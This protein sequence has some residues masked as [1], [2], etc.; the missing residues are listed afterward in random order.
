MRNYVKIVRNMKLAKTPIPEDATVEELTEGFQKGLR[1]LGIA[2]ESDLSITPI[3]DSTVNDKY[4]EALSQ[5]ETL[6]KANQA[7]LEI[8]KQYDLLNKQNNELQKAN[9][10]LRAAAQTQNGDTKK[11]DQLQV[12]I[13][14]ITAE[15]TEK[16]ARLM[17]LTK[18]AKV[19]QDNLNTNDKLI[20]DLGAQANTLKAKN[21]KFLKEITAK[22]TKI[23]D[24][25]EEMQ[26]ISELSGKEMKVLELE[27][28]KVKQQ[29]EICQTENDALRKEIENMIK[30]H[31]IPKSEDSELAKPEK[32]PS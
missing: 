7:L 4:K 6:E 16:N 1:S 27:S 17:E 10:E 25:A 32:S 20:E 14:K 28:A 21:D 13:T 11:V 26:G 22:E 12:E 29:L 18:K 9:D 24:L 3:T 8:G 2:G 31:G 30:I 19:M 15:M 5:I 23:K